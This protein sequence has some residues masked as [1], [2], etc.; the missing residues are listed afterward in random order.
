MARL[1]DTEGAG[2]IAERIRDRRGG[3]LRP[4]DGMLLYSPP[5]ADGWNQLLRA[6]RAE[7]TLPADLRE[8]VILRIGVLNHAQ[9]EWDSHEHIAR[10]AG[11]SEECLLAVTAPDAAAEPAFDHRT[12]TALAAADSLTRD[13]DL[14]DVEFA[15]IAAAFAPQEVVELLATIAVYNMVSRFARALRVTASTKSDA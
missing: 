15:R 14:S 1:P 3:R 11:V 12:R 6:I 10:Q 9:Y 8:L 5:V 13:A 2:D 4:I 7:T